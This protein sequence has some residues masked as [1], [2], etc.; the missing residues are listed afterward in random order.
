VPEK[1]EKSDSQRK[2]NLLHYL[3]TCISGT[4]ESVLQSQKK[5]F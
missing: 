1:L 5:E 2:S 4:K 3:Q